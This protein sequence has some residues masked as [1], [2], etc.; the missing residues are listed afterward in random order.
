[1]EKFGNYFWIQIKRAGKSLPS[2]L[3]QAAILMGIAALLFQMILNM[4]EGSADRQKVKIA[5]V[6]DLSDPYLEWGLYALEN[7]DVMH[8]AVEFVPMAKEEAVQKL[9]KG[10]AYAVIP[11]G[12]VDSIMRGENKKITYVTAGGSA[13]MI[14][15]MI[16]EV[17]E[18]MSV[19]L[20][21]TQNAIY[22]M[23]RVME[24]HGLESRMWEATE[25]IN[26]RYFDLF[27]NR[28]EVYETDLI[29]ISNE[30]SFFGYYV[31]SMLL[32]FLLLWGIACSPLFVKKDLAFQK[33]LR[34][35]GQGIWAQVIGEYAAYA[36][37]MT[38]GFL[39]IALPLLAGAEYLQFSIPEWGKAGFGEQMFFLVQ[40]FPVTA[41]LSAFQLFLFELV[42]GIVNGVLLQFLSAICMGYLSGCFYPLSFLPE[43]I[44]RIAAFLPSGMSLCYLDACMSGQGGIL[45]KLS[46]MAFSLL[47]FLGLTV[48]VRGRKLERS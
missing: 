38:V 14:S 40:V 24:N 13:D 7:L 45:Q 20:V 32:F 29:G 31:C 16:R 39:L 5:L 6:G 18:A 22:G 17:M 42:S 48:F 19:L 25:E 28:T 46:G 27:F 11:E 15:I 4:R 2:I 23:Q 43:G 9:D 34:A 26:L 12:L 35:R 44:R 33:L 41:L 36:V 21:E 37:L 47:L 8:F 10:Q 3:L 1:M 30:L